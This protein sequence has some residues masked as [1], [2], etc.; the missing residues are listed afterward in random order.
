MQTTD[1]AT[2]AA[3]ESIRECQRRNYEYFEQVYETEEKRRDGFT[4]NSSF[5]L[6][7]LGIAGT[8]YTFYLRDIIEWISQSG[9]STSSG[10]WTVIGYLFFALLDFLCLAVASYFLIRM[11]HGYTYQYLAPPLD[12][13]K[14]YEEILLP[15]YGN[16]IEA[17]GGFQTYLTAQYAAAANTND[18]NNITRRKYQYLC[19]TST[20]YLFALLAL[21]FLPFFAHKFIHR[22][23]QPLL[24]R[25]ENA[26]I[27]LEQ[28]TGYLSYPFDK[29][30]PRVELI[31]N[32]LLPHGGQAKADTTPSP[33]DTASDQNPSLETTPRASPTLHKRVVRKKGQGSN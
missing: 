17:E 23:K 12:I 19:L 4:T 26:R 27:T 32:P 25:W 8:I 31:P 18:Q 13:Q 6:G 5:L 14:Y 11:L 3:A 24:I 20:I 21:T 7:A 16:P 28:P 22:E 1:E 15:Y 9:V 2:E 29:Q 10:D 30:W 33:T